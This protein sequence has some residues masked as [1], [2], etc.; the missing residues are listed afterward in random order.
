[1]GEPA[2]LKMK[3]PWCGGHIEFETRHEFAVV[4]C[5]HC[6]K[7]LGLKS[8]APNIPKYPI[9]KSTTSSHRMDEIYG[10]TPKIT[11]WQMLIESNAADALT[12]FAVLNFIGA[13]IGG[14]IVGTNDI[15]EGCLIFICGVFGGLVLLGFAQIIDR[16]FKCSERLENIETLMDKIY[17]DKK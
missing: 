3:C 16:L 5:P 8:V 9:P 2:M 4:P 15:G 10:E 12:F 17:K 11:F 14:F 13:V 7:E 1:M 6:G